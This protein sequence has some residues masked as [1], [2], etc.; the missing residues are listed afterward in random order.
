MSPSP[1]RAT[2]GLV[3]LSAG[4]GLLGVWYLLYSARLT[5]FPPYDVVDLVIRHTPGAVATW[6]IESLEHRAQRVLQ[7]GSILAVV[8]AWGL[9]GSMATRV[10]TPRRG[11]VA[12]LA[13]LPLVLL[14]SW[15]AE[16]RL[17]AWRALWI[18]L[19]LGAPLAG[20]GALLGSWLQ[21]LTLDA[22]ARATLTATTRDWRSAPDTFDR[23]AVLRGALAIGLA[24]GGGGL[25]AG[26]L[27][28]R[29]NVRAPATAAGQSLESVRASAS[30]TGLPNVVRPALPAALPPVPEP[31]VFPAEARP[32]LT[33][34]ADF[35]VVD[36]S[37]RKPVIPE[38]E[39]Q[40]RVRGLVDRELTLTY[41]DLLAMRAVELDGTLM[42]ISYTHYND[43]ISST[44]WT[45]V[46]LRDVLSLAGMR[47]N[48][49]DV[50]CRG[51]H[52]YSDSIL[53]ADALAP[54]TL[55]AYGMNGATLPR[56]HGF[57][58]RLYVPGLYGEKNVKWLQ[59]IELV[60]YDYLGY[61][62]ERGWTDIAVI[63]TTAT[64]DS[65]RDIVA[66]D[67]DGLVPVYGIAYAG[68]RG[69]TSVEV[70]IDDAPWQPAE[71]EPY[72]PDLLWQRWLLRWQAEPGEHTLAV[73]CVDGDGN[74]QVETERRP[75]PD[76]MTGLDR[77][78]VAVT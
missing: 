15:W 59:E 28:R 41:A 71:L 19:A 14:L 72:A 18:A 10:A 47:P 58:C 48:A 57:P 42:C 76:G 33:P 3:S 66:R 54:H 75:H 37:F 53:L 56:E 4:A 23:R 2:A 8:A 9:A 25:L 26:M 62:Q 29:A 13:L 74:P 31:L 24:A 55:L 36:I 64:I 43:L 46:R 44:R 65:P 68:T 32:R 11:A 50:V 12:A 35:Y 67:P 5:P 51:T 17:S 49:F 39:W 38:S 60:D 45:G 16:G 52:G 30:T 20:C 73:R 70:R 40:L 21:R 27:L 63:N 69:I 22:T 77:V 6:A 1:S 7:A 61:W 78:R 34:N